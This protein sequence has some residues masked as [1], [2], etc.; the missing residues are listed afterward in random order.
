MNIPGQTIP[1]SNDAVAIWQVL[2]QIWHQ[3]ERLNDSLAG[4]RLH[5]LVL[6]H[7]TQEP[8]YDAEIEVRR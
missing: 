1:Q 8:L 3:L 5:V 2:E 6:D 4:A 7:I